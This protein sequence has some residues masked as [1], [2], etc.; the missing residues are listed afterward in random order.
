MYIYYIIDILYYITLYPPPCL[1]HAMACGFNLCSGILSGIPPVNLRNSKE[2]SS[3]SGSGIPEI[4]KINPSLSKT[5]FFIKMS[6]F[7]GVWQH[8]LRQV[9]LPLGPPSG[10]CF[11]F[12]FYPLFCEPVLVPRATKKEYSW[13]LCLQNG[14]FW[15]SFWRSFG[16]RLP[17][18]KWC[19]RVHE[20]S[21]FTLR[22]DPKSTK[23][24]VWLWRRSLT[25]LF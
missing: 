10:T 3:F 19:S 13:D 2:Q 8:V 7:T 21:I 9:L 18:W 20:S 11:S 23:K 24:L 12:F 25:P 1:R 5:L 6:I 17:K 16:V 14:H 4:L 22:A 15:L